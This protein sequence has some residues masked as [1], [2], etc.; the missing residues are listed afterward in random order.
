MPRQ[1]T[2][3]A[4]TVEVVCESC[5]K[6]YTIDRK[7]LRRRKHRACSLQCA[8]RLRRS[9]PRNVRRP[10]GP[11]L[12]RF[13]SK[14]L[15]SGPDDCW[16]WTGMTGGSN[17]YGVFSLG[18]GARE[19]AHRFSYAL[20]HSGIPDGMV[21]CHSCD[22]PR[23]VNPS[24][25][26]ADTQRANMLDCVSKNRFPYLSR[27]ATRPHT[28]LNPADILAIRQDHANGIATRALARAYAVDRKTIYEI[29]HRIIWRDV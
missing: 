28:K 12:E 14:V 1:Y 9:Y 5:G 11:V 8:R 6:A 15:V 21:V 4:S 23:C 19:R 3:D 16:L 26:Y 10:C 13:W 27:R 20:A 2:T 24:H 29:V 17:H 18:R 7:S 25:L 22:N